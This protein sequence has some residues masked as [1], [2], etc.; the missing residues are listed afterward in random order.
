MATRNDPF[1]LPY[2]TGA[3]PLA[4]KLHPFGASRPITETSNFAENAYI[5]VYAPGQ[6]NKQT[7]QK[8]A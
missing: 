3:W 7:H 8:N 2:P 6:E 1:G 5:L 4:S